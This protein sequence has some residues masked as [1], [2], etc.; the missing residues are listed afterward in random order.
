MADFTAKSAIARLSVWLIA[1]TNFVDRTIKSKA[2]NGGEIGMGLADWFRDFCG[3]IQV[4]DGSTISVRYKTITRR[5]NADFWQTNSDTSHSL[6][7]GSYGRN[8]VTKGFSDLDM[9]FQLPWSMYFRYNAYTSN[10]QSAL[11]QDV[12]RSIGKT[13]SSSRIGADGQVVEIAFTGGAKFEVVPAF[14]NTDRSF[15]FPDSNHGGSW[16][17]TNP[18]PEIEYIRARNNACNSNLIRLCRMM[19]AW[20]S[21][22]NVPMGG[23]LIDT[24]SYQFIGSWAYRSKSYLYYDWMCRDFFAH[25]A[26]QDRSQAYYRAPGSD[27]YVFNNGLFQSKARTCYNLAR[28]AIAHE[29]ATPKREWSAKQK[30]RDIFGNVFPR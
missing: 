21:E 15:T 14:E 26:A 13:Y 18:R 17:M 29:T 19:R 11:L 25:M 23:L 27:Q 7:V 16:K 12:R 24:L 9:I 22:W 8:T 4:Q 3:N 5:L 10:G 20:K 28:E 1:M 2:E 6:Y 30:W